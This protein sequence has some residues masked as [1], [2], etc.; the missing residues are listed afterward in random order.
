MIRACSVFDCTSA[1]TSPLHRFPKR[2]DIRE[3]WMKNLI[4]KPHK[5]DDIFKLRVCYKH[6]KES[7]Y[8]NSN[9]YNRL[10]LYNYKKTAHISEKQVQMQMKH[11]IQLQKIKEELETLKSQRQQQLQT[12][13]PNL[14]EIT[15]KN[16]LSPKARILYD[17]NIKLQA[18]KRRMMKVIKRLK[19]RNLNKTIKL[20]KINKTQEDKTAKVRKDFINMVLRNTNVLPQVT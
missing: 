7:D 9:K 20:T 13:R 5:E 14:A 4:L 12:K 15:R 11:N 16:N 19:Q 1:G 6:F 18:Q 10:I 17:N 8:T 3:K 2:L